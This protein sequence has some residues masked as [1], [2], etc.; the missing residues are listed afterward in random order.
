MTEAAFLGPAD[1]KVATEDLKADEK[2]SMEDF[3]PVAAM[4]LVESYVFSNLFSNFWL[5]L[6]NFER[7]VLGCIEAEFCK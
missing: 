2:G 6:A 4:V 1:E 3:E 5:I 7:L